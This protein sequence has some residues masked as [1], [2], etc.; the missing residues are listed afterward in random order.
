MSPVTKGNAKKT[1]ESDSDTDFQAPE[2]ESDD[3]DVPP[4]DGAD[5]AMELD[6]QLPIRSPRS[7]LVQTWPNI[8]SDRT[9]RRAEA[10]L[11]TPRSAPLHTGR[12]NSAESD[13][14]QYHPCIACGEH[15]DLGFCPLKM[16]GVE[17]CNLCGLAHYGFAR[18]C[19]HLNSVTQLRAMVEAMKKSPESNELKELAKKRVVGIIGDL[20][21]RKRRK[22]DAQQK[23]EGPLQPSSGQ[24]N[25][26]PPS[27][28]EPTGW[29]WGSGYL[30]N[31]AGN[32]N[33]M[34]RPL[35]SQPAQRTVNGA[36][37]EA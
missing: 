28:Y 11:L 21:A 3:A 33:L 5:A 22:Q 35:P 26:P 32:A 31:G 37:S 1:S 12:S 13:D 15:H 17:F 9:F 4:E 6:G 29:H 16:A 7:Q 10:S 2:E 36:W 30:V 19:P 14:A 25:P 24:Q 34:A 18:T 27:I 20:N 8:K 23:R